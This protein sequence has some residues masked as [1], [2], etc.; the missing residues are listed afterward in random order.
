[1]TE[2]VGTSEDEWEQATLEH[3]GELGWT[4]SRGPHIAPGT[5]ERDRWDDLAIPSRM[6]DALRRLNPDVP[7]TYLRQA[8]AEILAPSSEDPIAENHRIHDWLVGGFRAITYI[9]A[10]GA[11]L[12]QTL[13]RVNCT[14]R[15]KDAGL[16]V[17]YAPLAENL[18][19][20]LQEYSE[21][22]QEN[23]PLGRD[24]SEAVALLHEVLDE[25]RIPLRVRL[26]RP[27]PPGQAGLVQPR[28]DGDRQSRARPGDA[29]EPG[30]RG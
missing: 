19:K 9:D 24:V 20:A 18:Q 10:D 8:R 11:L 22:D 13:A 16:L 5:D 15:S 23:R 1:M 17:G 21:S 3:L 14:F 6:F 28:R 29:G 25:I 12:M 27:L 4:V 26:A 2:P 30:R 7:D